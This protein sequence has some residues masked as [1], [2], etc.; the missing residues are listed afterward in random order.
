MI[1]YFALLLIIVTCELI[2]GLYYAKIYLI[3]ISKQKIQEI[4]D[5]AFI[6]L[7]ALL[8]LIILEV[9]LIFVIVSWSSPNLIGQEVT[10]NGL[11][12]RSNAWRVARSSILFVSAGFTIAICILMIASWYLLAMDIRNLDNYQYN[13]VKLVRII[14][15]IISLSLFNIYFGLYLGNRIETNFFF[16]AVASLI[17]IGFI[18]SGWNFRKQ[19]IKSLGEIGEKDLRIQLVI[20]RVTTTACHC[21]VGMCIWL[22]GTVIRFTSPQVTSIYIGYSTLTLGDIIFSPLLLTGAVWVL[23]AM[24]NYG[25]LTLFHEGKKLTLP[26]KPINAQTIVANYEM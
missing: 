18:H 21:V 4:P 24:V 12:Y 6:S 3:T 15:F 9:Y 20:R 16:A 8:T 26:L 25:Q 11:Y 23:S 22:A 7:S 10:S 1:V 2:F 14:S 19:M 5:L 13:R 17:I